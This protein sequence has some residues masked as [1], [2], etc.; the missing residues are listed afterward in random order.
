MASVQVLRHQRTGVSRDRAPAYR[1]EGRD[2]SNRLLR[3]RIIFLGSEVRDDNANAICGQ[4]LLL[5][6]EDPERDIYLYINSLGGSI[7]AGMAIYDT[8]RFVTNDVATVGM[9]FAASPRPI[10]RSRPS[11]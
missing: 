3:E 2:V 5:N 9:G 8:M 7:Y 4:M 6:A 11:R 10:S 1:R